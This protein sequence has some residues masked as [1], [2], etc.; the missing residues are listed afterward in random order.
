MVRKARGG[1]VTG[2]RVFG[3]DIIA[4]NSH[5]ER[6]VNAAEAAVVQ[7]ACELYAGGLGYASI[8]AT[9]NAASEPAPRTWKDATSKWSAGSIRELVNRPLYRGEIVYGRT[10]KRNVDGTGR[11]DETSG[12]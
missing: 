6:R 8:A 11:S 9:L 10:K 2:G 12:V 1:H 3:Y 5:K 4:V 7:R